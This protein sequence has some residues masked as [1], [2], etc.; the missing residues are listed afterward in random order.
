VFRCYSVNTHDADLV[1]IGSGPGGYVGAIKASQL[2]M[3]VK[4]KIKSLRKNL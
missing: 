3:K 1:V 2:G 4:A